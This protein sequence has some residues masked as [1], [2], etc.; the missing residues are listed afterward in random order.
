MR[1]FLSIEATGRLRQKGFIY[2]TGKNTKLEGSML[3]KT[4]AVAALA[5]SL[6]AVGLPP[7][8]VRS[9]AG[10]SSQRER[11]LVGH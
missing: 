2:I 6:G 5:A 9:G 3:N 11:P 10:P 8:L 7:V 4:F 1:W